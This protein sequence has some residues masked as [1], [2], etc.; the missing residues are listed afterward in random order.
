MTETPRICLLIVEDHLVARLGM[1]GLLDYQPDMRVVAEAASGAEAV[2]RYREHRPDVVIMDLRLPGKD[3]VTATREIVAL[4]PGARILM[5]SSYDAEE[6]L[7]SAVAAG[8]SGYLLK[9]TDG[10][11]LIAAVRAVHRGERH[12]PGALA[13]RVALAHATPTLSPRD[14]ELLGLLA[15]GL[16]NGEI[17]ALMSLTRGTVRIYLSRLFSKLQVSNR[18]E[19]VTAAF[20]RGLIRAE[21]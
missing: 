18:T 16:N 21:E 3:G 15:K 17:A 19:A 11:E 9:S 8:A 14:R 6:D 4:D 20:E 2:E 12:F 10:P 1:R 13:D 5:F 7:R